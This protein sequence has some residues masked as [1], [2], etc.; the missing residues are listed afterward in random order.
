MSPVLIAILFFIFGGLIIS[1]IATAAEIKKHRPVEA[2]TD[3]EQYIVPGKVEMSVVEDTFLRQ[4]I[5]RQRIV[6]QQGGGSGRRSG[7]TGR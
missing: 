7:G 2:A 4:N 3:V 5:Q 6:Q 1:T